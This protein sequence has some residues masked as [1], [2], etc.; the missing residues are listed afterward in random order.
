M[1][2]IIPEYFYDYVCDFAYFLYQKPKRSVPKTTSKK[3]PKKKTDVK[4]KQGKKNKVSDKVVNGSAKEDLALM[5]NA[6]FE[7]TEMAEIKIDIAED[8]EE[9]EEDEE[10]LYVQA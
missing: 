8:N 10:V 3:K 1:E 7:D 5:D 4:A 6:G 2:T 9:E